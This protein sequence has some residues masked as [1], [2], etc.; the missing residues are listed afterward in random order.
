[1]NV[2][3]EVRNRYWLAGVL[4]GGL[5]GLAAATVGLAGEAAQHLHVRTLSPFPFPF[6]FP[7]SYLGRRGVA[8]A[9]ACFFG[10]LGLERLPGGGWLSFRAK[11]KV[12]KESCL[13]GGSGLELSALSGHRFAW[14]WVL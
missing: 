11:K 8:L 10:F 13:G 12:T 1:M 4:Q 3:P 2:G 6:P 9:F 5:I 7:F 14:P